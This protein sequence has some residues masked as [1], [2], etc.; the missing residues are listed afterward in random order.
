MTYKEL[1]EKYLNAEECKHFLDNLRYSPEKFVEYP[2][3][4]DVIYYAF[5]WSTTPQRQLYW[6]NV[7][8]KSGRQ[9]ITGSYAVLC[10]NTLTHQ[11]ELV[12][13]FMDQTIAVQYARQRKRQHKWFV[14][15][16]EQEDT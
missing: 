11:W 14:F 6:Q 16:V 10:K 8:E 4:G 2:L 3:V 12:A 9:R 7:Y 13:A 1:A 15:K 5:D